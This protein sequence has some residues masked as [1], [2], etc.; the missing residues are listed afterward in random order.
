MGVL[1]CDDDVEGSREHA[2]WEGSSGKAPTGVWVHEG[3]AEEKRES[4]DGKGSSGTRT[5]VL[6]CEYDAGE[7]HGEREN[8]SG[9]IRPKV[10]ALWT[11]LKSSCKSE[12]CQ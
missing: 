5:G 7:G 3:D 4:D 6:G 8:A 9:E 1:A 12:K 11:T 2:D 10:W